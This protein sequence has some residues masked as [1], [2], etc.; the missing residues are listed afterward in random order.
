MAD[1]VAA[2]LGIRDAAD[3]SSDDVKLI[4]ANKARV[5]DETFGPADYTYIVHAPACFGVR[6]G[7]AGSKTINSGNAFHAEVEAIAANTIHL[8]AHK[9]RL[10]D[11]LYAM[12]PHRRLKPVLVFLPMLAAHQRWLTTALQAMLSF[13]GFSLVASTTYNLN[14]L[15]DLAAGRV[16]PRKYQRLF[17]SGRIQ[18]FHGTWMVT[19]LGRAGKL[20][21]CGVPLSSQYAAAPV[22]GPQ[23]L[24]APAPE[25]HNVLAIHAKLP[26]SVEQGMIDGRRLRFIL[27]NGSSVSGPRLHGSALAV[28]GD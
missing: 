2:H 4:G 17:A 18:L 26:P 25:L 1:A 24:S 11:Y 13:V 28:C 15:A 6:Q 10:A 9:E 27:V 23:G 21:A 3:G 14:D 20:L 16:Q 19:V 22:T 12:R 7:A 8:P 5:L